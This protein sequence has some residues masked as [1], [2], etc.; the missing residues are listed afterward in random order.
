[1]TKRWT[2]FYSSF[3]KKWAVFN[4]YTKTISHYEDTKQDAFL[5]CYQWN[6]E[7]REF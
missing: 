5:I 4:N 6:K 2:F 3:F 1:M 7:K